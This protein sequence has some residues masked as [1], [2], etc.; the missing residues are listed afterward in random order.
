[1]IK[2][3]SF[4]FVV[5]FSMVLCLLLSGGFA[6]GSVNSKELVYAPPLNT[7]AAD[8][9]NSLLALSV[10]SP[11]SIEP[12]VTKVYKFNNHSQEPVAI[13]DLI[14]VEVNRFKEY[15]E[16]KICGEKNPCNAKI[17]LSLDNRKIPGIFSE[18]I[19]F[20]GEKGILHFRL[21]RDKTNDEIWSD[22]IG[23]ADPRTI[24]SPRR[25]ELSISPVIG[26]NGTPIAKSYSFELL[27]FRWIHMLFWTILL[28]LALTFILKWDIQKLLREDSSDEIAIAHRPYSLSRCQMLWWLFWIIVSYIFIY[29][30]TG[31][32]D[33]IT[34]TVLGL[35]GIGSA[36]TLG[37]VLI[38]A[39]DDFKPGNTRKSI[40]FWQDLL[41]SKYQKGA[42]L[43][44]LQLILWTM[45]L[46]VV[47]LVSVYSKLSMPQ[48]SPTLLALQGIASGTYLG[49]KFPEN[50]QGSAN[51][52][53]QGN[54]ENLSA[55]GG[56][57]DL[58]KSAVKSLIQTVNSSS[59]ELTVNSND[60]SSEQP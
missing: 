8:L 46:T 5:A 49:F 2:R 29:M 10:A 48:L 60:G 27:R 58:N 13:N 54:V 37:A 21:I 36:T 59:Q 43:H 57:Q 56:D 41:N 24:F 23:S 35:M 6:Q 26:E 14:V 52:E 19:I 28:L 39:N 30:A 31:A 50:K 15:Y 22:L 7:I 17:A 18:P 4:V 45:I 33:T 25:T 53:T 42:G 44:R 12:A 38:D 16:K 3:K 51:T 40:S 47:F 34:E 32:I 55:Q 20:E 1:M 9:D 11:E